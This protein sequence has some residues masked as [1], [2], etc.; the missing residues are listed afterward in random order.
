MLILLLLA[1]AGVLTRIDLR[2]CRNGPGIVRFGFALLWC[3]LLSSVVILKIVLGSKIS[4]LFFFLLMVLLLSL[5]FI[6][7]RPYQS[8]LLLRETLRLRLR[9]TDFV[10]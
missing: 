10:R 8:R 7:R 2:V 3:F 5:S 9:D 4:F 6:R 1:D